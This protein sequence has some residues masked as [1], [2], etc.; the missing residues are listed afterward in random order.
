MQQNARLTEHSLGPLPNFFWQRRHDT[1]RD[2]ASAF[3][4]DETR[5]RQGRG[6]AAQRAIAGRDCT[7][8]QTRDSRTHTA[9]RRHTRSR[10]GAA[11]LAPHHGRT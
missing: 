1:V 11:K 9:P 4:R 10:A 3:V 5:M 2:L 8:M 7:L 6:A